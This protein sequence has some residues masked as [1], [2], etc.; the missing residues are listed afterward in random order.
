[1]KTA[2]IA[3]VL[4]YASAMGIGQILF[5]SVAV[6]GAALPMSVIQRILFLATD[7]T[8][9]F[10]VLFYAMLTLIW[11]WILSFIPLS[12]AFPFTFMSILV[13]GLGGSILFG[14]QLTPNFYLGVGLVAVGLFVLSME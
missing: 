10:A 13:A 2:H 8:F 3:I 7:I 9:I 11:I 5:K 1:M 12:R 14:E 6:R 4:L